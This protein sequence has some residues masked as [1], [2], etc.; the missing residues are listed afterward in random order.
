MTILLL[1]L[2]ASCV[3][4]QHARN[5]FELDRQWLQS[6][7]ERFR[8][9]DI[10]RLTLLRAELKSVVV[11][12]KSSCQCDCELGQHETKLLLSEA[13]SLLEL[14]IRSGDLPPQW[15]SKLGRMEYKVRYCKKQPS[16]V[17]SAYLDT[18]LLVFRTSYLQD[19]K[20]LLIQEI[21]KARGDTVD[22]V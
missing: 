18:L 17:R 7:D 20:N 2:V 10:V 19:K 6:Y 11:L 9:D 16:E 3:S 4:E 15:K 22:R 13:T 14:A 1:L 12:W 8:Y 5:Q 21:R